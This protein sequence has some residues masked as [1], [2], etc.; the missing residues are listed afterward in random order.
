M[1]GFYC[2]FWAEIVILKI[3]C[4]IYEICWA[5]FFMGYRKIAEF[6][7]LVGWIEITGG[8]KDIWLTSHRPVNKWAAMVLINGCHGD[9]TVHVSSRASST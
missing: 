1:Y 9:A 5:R 4:K 6:S 8:L 7:V 3:G 2:F